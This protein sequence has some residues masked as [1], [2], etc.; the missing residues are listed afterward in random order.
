MNSFWRAWGR[1]KLTEVQINHDV[2]G[3][4]AV[5][6]GAPQAEDLTGKHPPDEANGVATLVV[7]GDGDINVLGGRVGIAEGDNGDV[8]VAGLLDGLVVGAR[9]GDDDQA[10][11]LE[12]AGDVV[13]QRTGGE[14]TGDGDGAGVSRELEDGTLAVGTGGDDADVGGVLDRGDDAGGEDNLLPGGNGLALRPFPR[15]PMFRCCPACWAARR[16]AI[17]P[18]RSETYQVLPMLITL[19]PSARVL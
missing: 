5:E 10:G 15:N 17:G 2:P 3:G 1:C 7:G 9:V 18:P 11:L 4:L 14:A 19:T 8:D 6:D 13:G 12:R 16:G